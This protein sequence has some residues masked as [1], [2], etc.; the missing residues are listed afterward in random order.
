MLGVNE[1]AN[2]LNKE[3]RCDN[4]VGPARAGKGDKADHALMVLL[5]LA[6][7]ESTHN[8]GGSNDSVEENAGIGDGR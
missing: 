6:Q 1:A 8:T 5:C 4:R 3:A 7:A 2:F